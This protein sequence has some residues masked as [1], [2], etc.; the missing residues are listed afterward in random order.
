[1]SAMQAVDFIGM[2]EGALALAQAAVYLSLAPKSNALYAGYGKVQEDVARTL[3]EP[4]P[5]HLR[6]PVTPLMKDVGYG[7]GYQYAHDFDDKTTGMQCL[8][9]ALRNRRYFLPTDEGFEARLKQR[10]DALQRLKHKKTE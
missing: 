1:M 9:D 4:V 3:A 5:L 6:N 8:P 7:R 2:P 10:L